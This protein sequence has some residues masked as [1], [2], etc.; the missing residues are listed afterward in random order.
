M[1]ELSE[2]SNQ[3]VPVLS[4]AMPEMCILQFWQADGTANSRI[5][6]LVLLADC[7]KANNAI[8]AFRP[9]DIAGGIKGNEVRRRI[10]PVGRRIFKNSASGQRLRGQRRRET[11]DTRDRAIIFGKPDRT[12]RG[13]WPDDTI[14]IA[15]PAG[16]GCLCE[17][18]S[19]GIKFTNPARALFG[20]PE[21]ARP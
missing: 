21:V 14:R 10:H 3:R 19:G 4:A 2:S 12:R 13:V 1:R 5:P 7:E 17:L 16:R 11:S 8:E 18:L 9:P 20:K 6:L 15:V